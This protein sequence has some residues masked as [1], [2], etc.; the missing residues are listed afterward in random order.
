MAFWGYCHLS[1]S[2]YF[3][4]MLT[5][6]NETHLIKS[7]LKYRRSF[8]KPVFYNRVPKCASGTVAQV[9]SSVARR[10]NFEW[11][12][13]SNYGQ[14]HIRGNLQVNLALHI[15]CY[16]K[17]LKVFQ[18]LSLFRITLTDRFWPDF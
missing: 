1:Y 6:T 10:N 17:A 11:I 5:G 13:S 4:D 8:G 7:M 2:W 15:L 9:L 3:S 16:K 14:S 12:S 18:L